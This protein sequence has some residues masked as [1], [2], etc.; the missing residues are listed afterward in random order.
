MSHNTKQH[1]QF[2][3]PNGVRV[4]IKDWSSFCTTFQSKVVLQTIFNDPI[5]EA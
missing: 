5:L 2:V 4:N 3:A 1:V